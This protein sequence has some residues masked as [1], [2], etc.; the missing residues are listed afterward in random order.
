MKLSCYSVLSLENI[1]QHVYLAIVVSQQ[2]RGY[3]EMEPNIDC[4]AHTKTNNLS[5][6][7]NFTLTSLFS[8]YPPIII[9][10]YHLLSYRHAIYLPCCNIDVSVSIWWNVTCENIL[11]KEILCILILFIETGIK[12][13]DL[14]LS[15]ILPK[16]YRLSRPNLIQLAQT[17][18]EEI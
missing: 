10:M 7:V 15:V 6:L 9:T 1:V 14:V 5:C 16:E 18:S 13:C 4:H 12:L 8:S 11:S 2:Y 17:F 3:V